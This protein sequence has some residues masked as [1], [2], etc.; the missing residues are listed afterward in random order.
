MMAR[1]LDAKTLLIH[2]K[3]S[4]PVLL[5]CCNL[6]YHSLFEPPRVDAGLALGIMSLAVEL[7]C[8]SSREKLEI[9][10]MWSKKKKNTLKFTG[11]YKPLKK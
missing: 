6:S 8:K 9:C 10:S 4:L 2:L 7:C 3:V 5:C 1:S 11:E